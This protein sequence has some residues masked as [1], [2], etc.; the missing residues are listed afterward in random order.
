MRNE[1]ENGSMM[2]LAPFLTSNFSLLPSVQ[3]CLATRWPRC[4]KREVRKGEVRNEGKTLITRSRPRPTSH[5]SLLL[6]GCSCAWLVQ[7]CTATL[8]ASVTNKNQGESE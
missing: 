7:G 2:G 1:I 3:A 8:P 4:Y 6:P 5:F